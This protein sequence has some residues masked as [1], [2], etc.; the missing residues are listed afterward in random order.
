MSTPRKTLSMEECLFGPE[1]KCPSNVWDAVLGGIVPSSAATTTIFSTK[2]TTSSTTTPLYLGI[3]DLDDGRWARPENQNHVIPMQELRR[4]ASQGIP[5]HRGVVWRVLLGGLPVETQEWKS[6]LLKK[7]MEYRH[8]VADLFVEPQHD[9]NDLRGHHGKKKQQAQAKRDYELNKGAGGGSAAS[10]APKPPQKATDLPTNTTVTITEHVAIQSQNSNNATEPDS[11]AESSVEKNNDPADAQNRSGTT[12]PTGDGTN[13]DATV[14]ANTNTSTRGNG[15][16]TKPTESPPDSETPRQRSRR[17]SVIENNIVA[18]SVDPSVKVSIPR[19]RKNMMDDMEQLSVHNP[20]NLDPLDDNETPQDEHAGFEFTTHD[21]LA[22]RTHTASAWIRRNSKDLDD[23]DLEGLDDLLQDEETKSCESLAEMVPV[24]IQEEWK[25]TGR[26]IATLD[27]LQNGHDLMNTLL[28][29]PDGPP[30]SGALISV[31]D[32]PLSTD[33]DSKW[34]QFFENASLL[35]EIRKDVVRT[36][37]ELYFF[38]EPENNLG[39]R[40]YAALERILFVWAKLN[41]GVSAIDVSLYTLLVHVIVSKQNVA[42]RLMLFRTITTLRLVPWAWRVSSGRVAC[43]TIR[44]FH[45]SR[46]LPGALRPRN[47]RNR[48]NHLLCSGQR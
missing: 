18:S 21:K 22:P 31:S 8:L 17:I 40:R 38:L 42:S 11:G 1:R 7:R 47:E 46:V 14:S 32:D 36:H 45:Y 35:D 29:V 2:K 37:P 13:S 30:K 23:L 34:F 26:D 28:V 20:K 3:D 39:Q 9:G 33:S 16:S 12:V 5:E 19:A 44:L 41:K 15:T 10:V 25:K 24:H 43:L 48:W 27:N 6:H 4:L